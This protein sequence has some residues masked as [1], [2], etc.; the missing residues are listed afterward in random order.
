MSAYNDDIEDIELA[1][2]ADLAEQMVFRLNGCTPT[3]IRKMLQIAYADFA[4]VTC[5][6]TNEYEFET[7]KDE[8]CYPV[9]NTLPK[10][11]VDSIGS[12][13]LDGRR[14]VCPRQ[15]RTSLLGGTP[16]IIFNDRTLAD[17][18][19]DEELLRHPEYSDR[20][21]DPQKVRVRIVEIPCMGSEEAPKWF[22]NKYGEAVVA[23]AL[24]RL[25]GMSNKSWTDSAQAQSEMIRYENFTTNARINSASEDPSQC[26]NGH[27]ETVDTSDLL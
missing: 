17:C 16:T 6:F 25:Y 21:Y 26:G 4:R 10:M 12:V 1:S 18:Y 14:L 9:A 20:A 2:I 27:I 11:Y 5:C 13:W 23:G 24:T 15:Y 8:I 19:N 3:L 22:L 7:E